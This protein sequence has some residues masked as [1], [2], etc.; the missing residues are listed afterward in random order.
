MNQNLDPWIPLEGDI[1]KKS[2]N[3]GYLRRR[4]NL[5]SNLNA[6]FALSFPERMPTILLE[7]PLSC[8]PEQ[9]EMLDCRGFQFKMMPW[10][11]SNGKLIL[12][13][14]HLADHQFRDVFAIIA[15]EIRLALDNVLDE[16]IAV[17]RLTKILHH[18][19]E[20]F[21]RYSG[22]PLTKEEQ[23]GLFGE[24][25]FLKNELLSRLDAHIAIA[26]W[27]GPDGAHQDFQT[28]SVAIEVKTTRMLPPEIVMI[29]NI[30]QL[31]DTSLP[32]LLLYHLSVD[33]RQDGEYGLMDMVKD[34]RL[35][36]E[37][38]HPACAA[39]FNIRLLRTG[40]RDADGQKYSATRFKIRHSHI[41]RVGPNFPC[42]REH[43]L[44]LGV[45]N[46]CYSIATA[47]C[48]DHKITIEEFEVLLTGNP[49]E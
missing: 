37:S 23:Q 27:T 34:L 43:D 40:Y 41:Y 10:D 13:A 42:L 12:L 15:E 35:S 16:L 47:A 18:W 6:F 25:W 31:D 45:G 44:P 46:V 30:L 2:D 33:P 28:S 8:A 39:E 36:L 14:L 21:Y 19:R 48:F 29:T 7:V 5:K 1:P 3:E 11:S 4:M 17:R 24:L 49:H 32:S 26:A 20:F 9:I 22:S 38:D